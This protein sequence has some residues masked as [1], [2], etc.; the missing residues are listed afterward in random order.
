MGGGISSNIDE[1]ELGYYSNWE[2]H[3]P[4][5]CAL[6]GYTGGDKSSHRETAAH[7]RKNIIW[8]HC[9]G[10]RLFHHQKSLGC[11]HVVSSCALWSYGW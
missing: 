4:D 6:V 5:A 10:N 8:S 7:I 1:S 9:I 2:L 3:L 11:P